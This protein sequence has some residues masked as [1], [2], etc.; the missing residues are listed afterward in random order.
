[1]KSHSLEITTGSV[2]TQREKTQY[3]DKN[4][5]KQHNIL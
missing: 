1:M 3:I 2:A 5:A 4:F